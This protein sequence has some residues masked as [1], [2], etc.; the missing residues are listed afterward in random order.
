MK[1]AENLTSGRNSDKAQT[2]RKAVFSTAVVAIS[3]A[4]YVAFGF[5]FD[6]FLE[7]IPLLAIPFI[8]VPFSSPKHLSKTYGKNIRRTDSAVPYSDV[9][10]AAGSRRIL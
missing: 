7:V 5:F 8:T 6:V 4:A 9:P 10:S 2:A 3:V 1:K